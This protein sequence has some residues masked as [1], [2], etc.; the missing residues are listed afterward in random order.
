MLVSIR[1]EIDKIHA[2]ANESAYRY[3]DVKCSEILEK[4]KKRGLVVEYI[5]KTEN[6]MTVTKSYLASFD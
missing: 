1:Q 3:M 2:I 6:T 5:I 4:L